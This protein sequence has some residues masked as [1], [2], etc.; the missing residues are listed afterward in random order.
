VPPL[1]H[2]SL[3]RLLRLVNQSLSSTTKYSEVLMPQ[4]VGLPYPA[5][6]LVVFEQGMEGPLARRRTSTHTRVHH[7]S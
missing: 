6:L 7:I 1:E 5:P 3:W 4:V 2:I